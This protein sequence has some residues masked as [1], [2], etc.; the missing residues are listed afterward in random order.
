MDYQY[1]GAEIPV[2][3]VG[4]MNLGTGKGYIGV[5]PYVG[6][7]FDARHKADGMDDIKLYEEIGNT[8]EYIM[9][10]WDVGAGIML[11]Y[12]FSNNLQINAGYK[13]GFLDGL[14]VGSDDATMLN[15][16]ISLGIGYRF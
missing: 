2:Y 16:T 10:R 11:G 3:A 9:Q 15:Q 7:G 5:G 14:G 8:G 4:Q 12:E 1:F 13:I 6:F